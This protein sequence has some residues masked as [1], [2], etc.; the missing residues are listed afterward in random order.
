VAA[1]VR[2]GG[3]EAVIEDDLRITTADAR[4]RRALEAVVAEMRLSSGYWPNPPLEVATMAGTR[5]GAM[6]VAFDPADRRADVIY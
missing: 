3:T 5:L 1:T 6:L 4:A 2:L